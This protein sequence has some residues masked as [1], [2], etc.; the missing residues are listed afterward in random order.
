MENKT[1][2]NY[3]SWLDNPSID[4]AT[5]EELKNIKDDFNEIEDRFYKDLQFG[6]A[7][8]RGVIGAGTNRMNKYTVRKATQGLADYITSN[9]E[10][11]KSRGVVIAYDSR[12][13]SREFSEE[14]ALVLAGNGI[15]SYLF[16]SLRAT[17]ELS[18]AVRHLNCISGIVVTASH[19]PP[20]YNGYKVYWDDGAQIA[21]ERAEAI[22]EAID[23]IKDYGSISVLDMETAKE[24]NLFSYVDKSVDESFINEVKKQ[25]L[26]AEIVSKVTDEFKIVFTP[27]HGTGNVPVRRIL[28][29]VGFKNVF[30]V[31][32]QEM[33][34]SEFPTVDYPNPE[35]EKA[36]TLGIE[37]AKE[38]EAH[39]I[40]ATDP[41]CDRVGVVTK[42]RDG[43]YQTL[44]GNQT[45]ALLVNYILSQLKAK[46]FLTKDHKM[47]KSV[48][49]SEMGTKIAASYGVEMLNT[50]TG[51]K[52][53]G[54]KIK[55][56][57]ITGQNKFVFGYEESYGYL[58]GTHARDKDAVVASMLICEM[59]AYYF[60]MDKT[61]SEALNDLYEQHG[62]FIETL[63]AITLAG[64][65]GLSKIADIMADFRSNKLEK[66][67]D[68]RVKYI[69][70]YE[71]KERTYI[72]EDKT[73]EPIDLPQANVIKFVLE[74]GSWVCLRP[75][76]TEPKLKIYIGVEEATLNK[77]KEEI[78]S[79]MNFMSNKVDSI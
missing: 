49:T 8:L 64:K 73:I 61:L 47:V 78:E 79:I 46:D 31:P 9:G 29:E 51:F 27:L 75:S 68:V 69:E 43:T 22:I 38:K 71:T 28:K 60:A 21:T 56:F 24:K 66:I 76:G 6:T 3:N 34:D 59:A 67:V 11:A 36:F 39:I 12:R 55:E 26:G 48:V 16:D 40:I 10:E 74:N 2:Q 52:Y 44:T 19:N 54:E 17:P 42:D 58:A 13:M 62:Y 23:N 14:A 30:V 72:S 65:E 18:Y 45:G 53:I 77:S 1:L 7:G 25:S 32:K 37:L 70:D 50:L 15:R 5:K 35:D 4:E 63:K 33:P 57:E 41:D 20:E